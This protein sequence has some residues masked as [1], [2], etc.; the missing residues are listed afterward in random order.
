MRNCC[1]LFLLFALAAR[2]AEGPYYVTYSS[3]MEEP[4][5]LEFALDQAAG[6]PRGGRG[7]LSSLL[8]IEYGVKTW[9]T[10][11]AY[12]SGQATRG[13]G[14]LFTGYRFENRFRPWMGE[15]RINPV[16]YVEFEDINGAEKSL[17]EVVGHDGEADQLERNAEARLERKRELETKLIL[18][19]NVRGWDISENAI[20]EK[21]LAGET[22]EFGYAFGVSRPL[23]F[24]A[25]AR[26]CNFCRENFTLGA[27]MFGGLGTWRQFG[28]AD[29]SHYL[30]PLVAWDLPSGTRLTISPAF[31]LNGNS[32]RVLLRFSLS[33]EL[34]QAGRRMARFF[35]G[36]QGEPTAPPAPLDDSPFAAGAK[37]YSRHCA[38][39]HG[40]NADG[41]G[42]APALRSPA[43]R[44]LPSEALFDVVT[45]GS[46]RRGMPP[47]GHLPAEQR[48]QIV[49]YVKSL[50]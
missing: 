12:F 42:R 20:A 35:R 30:A 19:S 37:L 6:V 21:N 15:H 3:Q 16:F 18:S 31:G 8:E 36:R 45:N 5:N 47:W 9:W 22:W 43:V 17:K 10:A 7:F 4:G 13:Q 34:E 25:S 41:Y 39:C 24:A 1:L 23:A 28:L 14:A 46:M 26:P 33:Y 11:E 32:H 38:Q 40:P 2:G 50:K 48:R 49:A 27:E 44:A 29:T